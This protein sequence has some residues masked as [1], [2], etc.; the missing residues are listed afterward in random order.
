MKAKI[1]SESTQKDASAPSFGQT[2]RS[3]G[4]D[5]NAQ[6]AQMGIAANSDVSQTRL[7]NL[8]R[9]ANTNTADLPSGLIQRIKVGDSGASAMMLAVRD[10]PREAFDAAK[11]VLDSLQE[12]ETD[13]DDVAAIIAHVKADSTVA[14]KLPSAEA[15]EDARREEEEREAIERAAEEA[16]RAR[17]AAIIRG[18]RE[19][20][21]VDSV[22]RYN[23]TEYDIKNGTF[24][25][26]EPDEDGGGR[27]A[28]DYILI[29]SIPFGGS[30]G[31]TRI[32]F[33]IH[34][35]PGVGRKPLPGFYNVGGGPPMPDASGDIIDYAVG[36]FGRPDV[37]D[38]RD[39]RRWR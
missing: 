21:V 9:V 32:S 18:R 25:Q 15:V 29:V 10:F 33:H 19:S 6:L 20:D 28:G 5:G 1:P 36:H 3:T 23:I 7:R 30:T 16:L 38:K 24:R 22:G 34:P 26:M 35:P 14:A 8:Q 27:R 12:A 13:F 4:S 11:A 39:D 37:W 2:R 31:L 17:V